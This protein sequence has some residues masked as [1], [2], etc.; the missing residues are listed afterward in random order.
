MRRWIKT[1]PVTEVEE[2][3]DGERLRDSFKVSAGV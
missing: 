1:V 2:G 3:G